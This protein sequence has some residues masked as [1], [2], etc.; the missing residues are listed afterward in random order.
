MWEWYWQS[1]HCHLV[2]VLCSPMPSL[3]PFE[4]IFNLLVC[5]IYT[6]TAYSYQEK[7]KIRDRVTCSY[8][9]F[10]LHIQWFQPMV[11]GCVSGLVGQGNARKATVG[12][13]RPWSLNLG[14]NT[15]VLF[16]ITIIQCGRQH[17]VSWAVRHKRLFCIVFMQSGRWNCPLY[18]VERCPLF[19]GVNVQHKRCFNPD[20]SNCPL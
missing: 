20:I 14:G 2:C 1:Y 6:A 4:I 19:R 11:S 9:L 10:N 8:V 7:Q 16:I 12:S 13:H 5:I 15:H 3:H 17:E 18:G